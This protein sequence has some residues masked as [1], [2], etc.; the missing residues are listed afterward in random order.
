MCLSRGSIPALVMS[1]FAHTHSITQVTIHRQLGEMLS[2]ESRQFV[3]GGLLCA[4]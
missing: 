3:I 2:L 4:F 1:V